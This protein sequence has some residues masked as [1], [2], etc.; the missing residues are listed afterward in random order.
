VDVDD[1]LVVSRGNG[2]VDGM[3]HSEAT[4]GVW[5]V[6]RLQRIHNFLCSMLVFTPF[7]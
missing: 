6:I 4:Q 2:V 5:S 7:A 1:A 3:Q